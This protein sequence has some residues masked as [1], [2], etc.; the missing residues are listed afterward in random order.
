[1]NKPDLLQ[2]LRHYDIDVTDG[3]VEQLCLCPVHSESRP[4]CSVNSVK[5]VFNCKACS[6]QGDSLELIQMREGFKHF[7]EVIEFAKSHFGFEPEQRGGRAGL[8]G[9]SRP[10]RG[11]GYRP[12]FKRRGLGG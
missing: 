12:A 1:M 9:G 6:A 2:V 7:A 11:G 8:S 3:R 4:S 5:Q 10:A